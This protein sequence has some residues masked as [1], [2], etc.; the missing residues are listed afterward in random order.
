[1]LLQRRNFQPNTSGENLVCARK[2]R[3]SDVF[4]RDQISRINVSYGIGWCCSGIQTKSCGTTGMYYIQDNFAYGHVRLAG[5]ENREEFDTRR[6][7]RCFS[8]CISYW[9]QAC[10]FSLKQ[11][12]ADWN[13]VIQIQAQLRESV[14]HALL[15]GWRMLSAPSHVFEEVHLTN[16]R[17]SEAIVYKQSLV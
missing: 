8:L 3:I 6:N 11:I 7:L 14:V 13:L 1:M 4:H 12:R 5:F 9:S 15:L 17:Q 10:P 16:A 2:R